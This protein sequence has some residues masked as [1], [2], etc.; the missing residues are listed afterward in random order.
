[1]HVSEV[2]KYTNM[3][4]GEE[5]RVLFREVS[6]F[7][8]RPYRGVPLCLCMILCPA[9]LGSRIPAPRSSSS[10]HTA[11]TQ[12]LKARNVYSKQSTPPIQVRLI[13]ICCGGF[14]CCTVE[15]LN[16]RHIVMD[17]FVHYREVVLLVCH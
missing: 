10:P 1:M 16:N 17:H 13:T 5:E 7:Q 15:P 11:L 2:E 9:P 12:S 4:L 8:G 14:Q 3:V 6:L